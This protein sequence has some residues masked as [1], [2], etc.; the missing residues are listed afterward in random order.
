VAALRER[1]IT[2]LD[3]IYP[4]R[5]RQLPDPPI[6]LHFR[7]D[8]S[9]LGRPMLAMVGSR[10]A[11][12]YAI[13]AAEHLARG[14]AEIGFAI[15]SGLAVGVDAAAHRAALECGGK[16]VAVLGN[17]INVDYP[18]A[19][20]RLRRQIESAGLVLTEFPPGAPPHKM[21]FPVRNRII[22][23]LS[24]GAV[25]VEAGARS[26][27]LITARTAL[28]QNREVFCV[29]GSIFSPGS[30]G[31]H[32]LVQ[33]GAKLVHDIND[34]LDE[35]PQD[36]PLTPRSTS[37]APTE[38]DSPLREVLAAFHR[39]FATRLEDAALA[40]GRSPA[41]VAESLLELELGGWLR[42]LPG[43]RYVRSK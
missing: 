33:T 5:L 1:V 13:N 10:R 24:L 12:P 20:D 41:A 8:R 16:T 11:S 37:T 27:S 30:E 34:I 25:I 38:P 19:N 31:P 17:G 32:R 23:G 18:R 21:H 28:E 40:L 39:E 14:L 26:G 7:G 4:E 2:R 9:L 36:L 42:A 6:V 35:L 22:S 15:V 3:P 29:P 43:A